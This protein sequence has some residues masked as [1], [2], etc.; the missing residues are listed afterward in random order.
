M[1]KKKAGRP[2]SSP[3]DPVIGERIKEARLLMQPKMT[4]EDLAIA[5]NVSRDTI[6]NW[7]KGRSRPDQEETY[8]KLASILNVSADWLKNM[9]VADIIKKSK[10]ILTNFDIKSWDCYNP[11]SLKEEARS[12]ALIYSLTMCGYKLE[13]IFN[14]KQYSEYM[15][16]SIR[17]SIDFYMQNL[18][19]K[20]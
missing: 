8:L 9:E 14:K 2:K 6:R 19:K 3:I 16:S 7:E 15:E 10:Q 17:N 20:G 18:N 1:E 5:M 11:P 12:Y 13:D 4:Q